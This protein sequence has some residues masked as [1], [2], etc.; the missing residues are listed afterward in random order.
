MVQIFEHQLDYCANKKVQ[1]KFLFKTLVSTVGEVRLHGR[2]LDAANFP[3]LKL[4][5]VSRSRWLQLSGDYNRKKSLVLHEYLGIL[6]IDDSNYSI[7][8]R[9]IKEHIR[10]DW[11][12]QNIALDRCTSDEV[13]NFLVKIESCVEMMTGT[14]ASLGSG[15]IDQIIGFAKA[16]KYTECLVNKLRAKKRVASMSSNEIISE[17]SE[18]FERDFSEKQFCF[19]AR[20]TKRLIELE[21]QGMQ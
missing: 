9:M 14:V 6:K 2:D 16:R 12:K 8:G 15:S 7:S 17:F 4:I 10:R 13:S 11:I 19:L 5:I 18:F 3:E 21:D 20:S 1:V